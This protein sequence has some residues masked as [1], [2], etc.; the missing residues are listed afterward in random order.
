MRHLLLCSILTACAPAQPDTVTPEQARQKKIDALQARAS[1]CPAGNVDVCLGLAELVRG[2]AEFVRGDARYR[3]I[4]DGLIANACRAGD[5]SSCR[6]VE[7][8]ARDVEAAAKHAEYEA[9]M[10]D[11][12]QAEVEQVK[13]GMTREQVDEI[14]G[15]AGKLET[16]TVTEAGER[17]AYTWSNSTGSALRVVFRDGVASEIAVLSAL[18]E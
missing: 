6:I 12:T 16:R 4:Y 17:S 13:P 8:R 18:P 2:S 1:E 10:K 14:I 5:Q 11:V 3:E 9:R 15:L 7:A